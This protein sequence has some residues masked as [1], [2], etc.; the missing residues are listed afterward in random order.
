MEER[1][2]E[3]IWYTQRLSPLKIYGNVATM[4]IVDGVHV[5]S[6][7]A[8]GPTLDHRGTKSMIFLSAVCDGNL[9]KIHS[10]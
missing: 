6:L 8:V 1:T 9:T 2:R 10:L 7:A 3:T 4:L 5:R